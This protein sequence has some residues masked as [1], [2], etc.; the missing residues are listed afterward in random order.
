MADTSG[1]AELEKEAKKILN[2]FLSGESGETSPPK[3]LAKVL[4]K[5]PDDKCLYERGV[6]PRRRT[7]CR[8]L[9]LR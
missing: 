9:D 1:V 7:C 6:Y 8:D 2:R 4:K 5:L 3:E